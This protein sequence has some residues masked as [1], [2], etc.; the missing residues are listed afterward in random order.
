[1]KKKIIYSILS[2]V[3][4]VVIINYVPFMRIFTGEHWYYSNYDGSFRDDEILSRGRT[5]QSV[6]ERYNGFLERHPEKKI[7][8]NLYINDKKNYLKFWN[9]KDYG[10]HPRWHLP[11]K[12]LDSLR[13]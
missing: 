11:Y 10:D 4:F 2:F 12:D 1:M 9:Y 3:I 8:T 5:L 6:I 13:E 7:D